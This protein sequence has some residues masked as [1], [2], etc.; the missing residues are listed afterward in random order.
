MGDGM[1]DRQRPSG[2]GQRNG[3]LKMDDRERP[4]EGGQKKM[5]ENK[6]PT[7]T[8]WEKIEASGRALNEGWLG[9]PKNVFKR[10]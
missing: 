4:T 1:A 6:K 2:S 3:R 7:Q 9:A 10:F 5:G 8:N